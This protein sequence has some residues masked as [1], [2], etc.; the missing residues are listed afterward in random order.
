MNPKAASHRW[1]ALV[2]A[3]L[4]LT[5]ALLAQAVPVEL[6][7]HPDSQWQLRRG[8]QPYYIMGAG[9]D[10]SKE[11]LA[12]CGANTFRTWGVGPDLGRQLDQAQALGLTV[13]V[14]HWLGHERH[15]FDYRD[16]LVLAEQEARVRR[17]VLAYKDHPALLIWALGNE[18]E[19]IGEGDDPAIWTHIQR[20]AAMVHEIDPNHPTMVVTADIGGKRVEAIHKLCP[21][22]DI[23]GINTYGGL[24]S[25][26][27]RYRK[28]SGTKPYVVTEFGPPGVWETGR[29]AF[30]VPPELTSTQKAALYRDYFQ[31]GCLAASG[32]CLG[33]CAFIWGHKPETTATW[34]GMFLPNGDKL[35]AVDSMTEVWSGHAPANLCPR[36]VSFQ[37]LGSDVLQ[38]GE[39]L[40]AA[41][42]VVD[43]E[44]SAVAV[45]WRVCTEAPEYMTF[46]ETWWQPLELGG[47]IAESSSTGAE[48]VM[49][50]AAGIYRLYVVASDGSG[51]A[52]TAN[53]PFQVKGEPGILR[54]KLPLTVYADGA[55]QPWA[56]SGW[57]GNHEGLSMDPGSRESPHSGDTCL[58]FHYQATQDWVGVAW[59]DP[60]NNWGG[61]PG[62]YDLSGAKQLSF[63]ARGEYGGEMVDFGVGLASDAALYP[64]TVSAQ[65]KGVK[66]SS[67][68][69]RYRISLKGQDLTR[70][71]TP[72]Y[73]TLVG[74]GRSITLYLDDIRFE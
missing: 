23:L 39:T 62:G 43:P 18:M 5:P 17:D 64:D 35:G 46:G 13:I 2:P 42:E 51:G 28:L 24:P 10:G 11:L 37:L 40:K 71:R 52:A 31:Q 12:A 48:L 63:W 3:F 61:L 30:G 16:S 49:P 41:L 70:V 26:P 34:F 73:F 8:G 45:D 22:I 68:W 32:L 74:R 38:S 44:G 4:L 9:G 27:E 19:G 15:G 29:T 69:K 67:D 25:L 60:P 59:Q 6:V 56:P 14:G 58:K 72:F 33:G 36:I 20:L 50:S 1:L 54:L 53:I 55:P 57:M 21:D 66:L 7:W 47:I 65:L